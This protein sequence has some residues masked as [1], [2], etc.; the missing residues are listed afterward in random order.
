MEVSCMRGRF[1][2]S[3]LFQKSFGIL[4]VVFREAGMK[5]GVDLKP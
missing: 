2:S 1:S 3:M 4:P 5:E